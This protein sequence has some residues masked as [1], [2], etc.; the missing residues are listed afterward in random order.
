MPV[1]MHLTDNELDDEYGLGPVRELTYDEAFSMLDRNARERLNMPGEEFLRRWRADDFSEEFKDEHH[2][3]YVALSM[4]AAPFGG[5]VLAESQT[6]AVEMQL[7]DTEP[8]EEY[9]LIPVRELTHEEAF[10]VLDKQAWR[11][12]NMS[13][14][15]FLQRWRA[16]NFTEEFK[17]EHHS[18]YAYLSIVVAPFV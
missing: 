12:L 3:E 9:G 15:E 7:V 2:S 14:E 10:A 17:D 16:N 8:D 18:A 11:R 6:V 4:M 1:G 5:R 13:G